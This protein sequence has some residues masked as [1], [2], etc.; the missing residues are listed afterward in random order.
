MD[1]LRRHAERLG[2]RRRRHLGGDAADRGGPCALWLAKYGDQFPAGWVRVQA[3]RHALFESAKNRGKDLAHIGVGLLDAG[4][5]LSA[6]TLAKVKAAYQAGKLPHVAPDSVSIP[7]VRLLFGLPPPGPGVDEMYETEM[8]QLMFRS[9][10]KELVAAFEADP[11]GGKQLAPAAAKRLRD[12][13]LREPDM[14]KTL[15]AHLKG[16]GGRQA[17]ADAGELPGSLPQALR[18]VVVLRR[19]ARLLDLALV[20]IFA[21]DRR[22][23]GARRRD[24]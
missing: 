7:F 9:K 1:A 4:A 10:N 3:C 11:N 19:A 5:M 18:R 16:G 6:A 20:E 22:D 15:K 17:L 13:F 23:V 14:S 12:A 24:G 21:A 8:A 2:P